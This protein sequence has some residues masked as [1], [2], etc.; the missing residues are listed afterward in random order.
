MSKERDIVISPVTFI[1]DEIEVD[2]NVNNLFTLPYKTKIIGDMNRSV[3][4]DQI[5]KSPKDNSISNSCYGM[6][7]SICKASASSI[8][9]YAISNIH[10]LVMRTLFNFS[11]YVDNIV[12]K[13]IGG[14][15]IMELSN[16]A[17]KIITDCLNYIYIEYPDESLN[18]V[19]VNI[20]ALMDQIFSELVAKVFDHAVTN[21]VIYVSEYGD[22]TK[23]F[24]CIFKDC[25]G[26][27]STG[28]PNKDVMYTFC[29]SILRDIMNNAVI[30]F[31]KSLSFIAETLVNMIYYNPN[32][33]N[34]ENLNDNDYYTYDMYSNND[35][36]KRY[37]VI[38]NNGNIVD[39]IPILESERNDK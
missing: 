6:Y 2:N 36:L 14:Y 35:M 34:I 24:K 19:K 12:G 8:K 30:E 7:N 16:E 26:T 31:R 10:D 3:V 17:N 28:T 1:G 4:I 33:Y 27:D 39:P 11:S 22:L 29:T 21:F 25:Y 23:L 5:K 13:N 15:Y 20:N 32:Y 18:F 9:A 37:I 38:N